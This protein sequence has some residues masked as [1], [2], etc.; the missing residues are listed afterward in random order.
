MPVVSAYIAAVQAEFEPAVYRQAES[1][2]TAADSA[3][4]AVV[5]KSAQCQRNLAQAVCN[6]AVAA[7]IAVE[8]AEFV[9]V[10]CKAASA[11]TPA[12]YLCA[13]AVNIQAVSAAAAE[14]VCIA[15]ECIAAALL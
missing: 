5:C 6:L 12:E 13:E 10:V 8:Q 14:P 7:C 15:A 2:C 11:C 4:P 9:P 1:V 3:E